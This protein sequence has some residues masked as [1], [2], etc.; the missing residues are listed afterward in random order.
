M[1]DGWMFGMGWWWIV[2]LIL[3]S[4]SSGLCSVRNR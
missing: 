1:H 4:G 2:V 3:V